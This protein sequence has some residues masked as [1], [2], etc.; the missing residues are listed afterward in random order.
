MLPHVLGY[1][2]FIATIVVM[3]VHFE[4]SKYELH[5][6][7][8]GDLQIPEWINAAIYGTF[9]IFSSFTVVQILG[10]ALPP[11]FYG[12]FSELTYCALS[13]TAKLYLGALYVFNVIVQEQRAAD[14][15]GSTGLETTR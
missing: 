9:A 15:L 3:V 12:G 4:T 6:S 13:L 1:I 5:Q 14:I 2:P 7:T 10:Q 8:N 11:G